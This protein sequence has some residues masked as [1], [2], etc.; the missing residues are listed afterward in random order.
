MLEVLVAAAL[1][2]IGAVAGLGIMAGTAEGV[3]F[4]QDRSRALVFARSKLEEILKE[5]VLAVG[6]DRGEGVDTT[7]EYDWVAV[8]EETSRPDLVTVIV[9]ATN[10]NSQRTVTISAIRRLDLNPPEST[11]ATA[12]GAAPTG[13]ST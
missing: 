11:E 12:G 2:G 9:R 8:I 1:L 6:S 3:R 13:G 7:T 10:R 5:P 4:A